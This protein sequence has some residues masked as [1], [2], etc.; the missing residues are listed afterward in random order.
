MNNLKITFVYPTDPLGAKIGGIET[1]IKG[2]IEHSPDDFDIEFVGVS[3]DGEK[4]PVRRWHNLKLKNKNLKVFYLF[5]E[6]DINRRKF[7]PLSLRFM[8]ALAFSRLNLGGR[9]LIFNRVEPALLFKKTKA[10]KIL[11][12]HSDITRQILK[13]ESETGWNRLPNLY[14][15]LEKYIFSYADYICT[16]SRRTLVYYL[17]H[18]P[19]KKDKLLYLSVWT[20]PYIF[21]P[22]DTDKA[23]AKKGIS[24][25]DK[26]LP[27]DQ[28]WI[29]SVGRL[30]EVKAPFRLIDTFMEYCKKDTG[31]CLI[32]I[33]GGNLKQDLLKYVAKNRLSD[34]V[35]FLKEMAQN[36]L[37]N[38]Y[39]A[40]DLLLIT[41]NFEGGPR[42]LFEALSS[43]LP[44]VSTDVGEAGRIIRN[45][46][47]GEVVRDFCAQELASAV[48]KVLRNPSIYT[49]DK[50]ISCITE[51]T[52]E[53]ILQPV[54]DIIRRLQG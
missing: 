51:Y 19:D 17:E 26:A 12:N 20:D 46:F 41:S 37:A 52:P 28:K 7:I 3:S 8:F 2:F 53:K 23:D 50:C 45:N 44:V 30:Q 47:S 35:F 22:I 39:R 11:F 29:L 25:T 18:Y 38:F 33:G 27:V 16:S 43:G 54:Y 1:F 34:K 9:T 40:S 6:K 32:I 14:F 13:R 5:F 48:D 49:R 42:T 21:H 4:R 36:D 10:H 31:V 15:A 24:K